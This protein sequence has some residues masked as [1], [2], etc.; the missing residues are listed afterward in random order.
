MLVTEVV[1]AWHGE[2]EIELGGDLIFSR[3]KEDRFPEYQE[4]REALE[5]RLGPPPHWR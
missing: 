2:F 3:L 1:P 5:H 4:L